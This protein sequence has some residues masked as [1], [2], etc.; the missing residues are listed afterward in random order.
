MFILRYE[1]FEPKIENTTMQKMI[2]EKTDEPI[3]Y[4][5]A[6]IEGYK[7]HSESRDE[8]IVDPETLEL[9]GE[10]KLGYVHYPS[11]VQVGYDYDFKENQHK[12]YAVKD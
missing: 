8:E 4:R 5:I 12:I 9:T 7:L 10:T 2:D 11:F 1:E 6:P 3:A